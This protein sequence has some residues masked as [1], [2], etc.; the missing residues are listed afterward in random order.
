MR[1]IKTGAE[2]NFGKSE[3]YIPLQLKPFH[4]IKIIHILQKTF[5]FGNAPKGRSKINLQLH[6][7]QIFGPFKF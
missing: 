7:A 4:A 3:V 2:D 5:I 6:F 1:Y